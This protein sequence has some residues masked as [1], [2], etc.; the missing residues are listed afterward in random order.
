MVSI[1][2]KIILVKAYHSISKVEQYYTIVCQAY[3]I[4]NAEI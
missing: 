4:I 3:F 1:K 2:V